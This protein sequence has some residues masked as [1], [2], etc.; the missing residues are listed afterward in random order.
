MNRYAASISQHPVAAQAVGELAGSV[1]EQLDGRTIDLVV[2]F[3]SPHFAGASEDIAGV[4]AAVLDPEVMVGST[5]A[6]IIGSG[7]EVEDG[8]AISVWAASF[9]ANT[10]VR[11][12]DLDESPAD[13]THSETR[14]S[15]DDH[16]LV[17][18][19]DP[20]TVPVE[21]LLR[22]IS[23]RTPDLQVIGGMASAAAGP[24]GNRIILDGHARDHGAVG[25]V[26]AGSDPVTAVVSQGCRPVGQPFVVTD[27]DGHYVRGLGGRSALE[28]LQEL[29]ATMSEVERDQLQRGLHVGLVVDEHRVEFGRED[30]LIRGV[31][32]A[33]ADDG[34]IAIGAQVEVGQ[35]LQFHVRDAIAAGADLRAMLAGLN[36]RAGLLFTC[37]GR[38]RRLFGTDGH[39]A[40]MVADL[41]GPIPVAGGFCAGEIGPVGATNHIHGITAS[42]AL[43]P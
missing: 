5:N 40:A 39:D 38:G 32:G 35:T 18:L 15:D 31:M 27:V 8:P 28:R 20:F 30:F 34:A 26:L 25:V 16:T 13:P 37:T 11:A 4:L 19:A 14:G 33:R 23:E 10:R 36:A 41:L 9:D 42:L 43:F 7:R 2:G 1:L 12:V 24:G 17:L 3:V 22:S 21:G 29:A 6:A